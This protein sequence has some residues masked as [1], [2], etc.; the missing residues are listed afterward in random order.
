MNVMDWTNAIYLFVLKACLTCDALVNPDCTSYM[1]RDAGY[2]DDYK[3][4]GEYR[5]M[6]LFYS[7]CVCIQLLKILS[8][9]LQ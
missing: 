8:S 9:P 2:F 6:K 4:T 5:T 7:M 1:C 3:L